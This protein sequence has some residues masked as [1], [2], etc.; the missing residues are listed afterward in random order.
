MIAKDFILECSYELQEK[1][2]DK[3]FWEDTELFI[4]LQRAYKTLQNDIPCFIA[5]ESIDIKEGVNLYNLKFISLKGISLFVNNNKYTEHEKEYIFKNLNDE[6]IYN[7][8]HKE[9]L[10]YPIPKNDSK[11]IITYYYHKELG[12][13]NDYITTPIEYEEAL[14]FIF[15][16]YIFEKAPR[17]SNERDLSIHYLKRY[18]AKINS[19]K[20]KKNKKSISSSYQRI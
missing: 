19:L 9:L 12:N 7:I 14:R 11:A 16:S 1:S 6:K 18:E 2:K 17:N 13:E 3:K 10:L 5:N 4:K 20:I 15:L 8:F